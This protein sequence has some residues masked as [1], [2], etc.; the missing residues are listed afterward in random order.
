M[1]GRNPGFRRMRSTSCDV[2]VSG[3]PRCVLACV[4]SSL[5]AMT[6][7]VKAPEQARKTSRVKGL[8]AAAVMTG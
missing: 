1:L 3:S 4:G 2:W 8:P 6:W 7:Y 5:L